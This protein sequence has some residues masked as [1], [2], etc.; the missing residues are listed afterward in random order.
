MSQSVV[1]H[2]FPLRSFPWQPIDEASLPFSSTWRFEIVRLLK[3]SGATYVPSERNLLLIVLFFTCCL[4]RP[5]TVWASSGCV[6]GSGTCSD[7]FAGAAGTTLSAYSASW[8]KLAGSADLYTMGDGSASINGQN[9]AVY[10]FALS[11]S[12]TSQITVNPSTT[13]SAYARDACVR[14][15]NKGNYCVG[16]GGVS[17]GFYNNCYVVKSGEYIGS[18]SCVSLQA[19]TNHTLALQASG[20][21]SVTLTIYVDGSS[22]GSVKD[23]ANALTSG[24]PGFMIIGDGT[25]SDTE[26][27]AWQDYIGTANTASAPAAAGLGIPTTLAFGCPSGSGSCYDTFTGTKNLP[28]TTYNPVWLQVN[29][30]AAAFLTGN[31]SVEIP[32]TSYAYYAYTASS[33]DTAQVTVNPSLARNAYAREACVR[34]THNVGGYCVGFGQAVSGSYSGCFVEMGGQYLGNGNCGLPSAALSH[35]LAI[36]AV[37]SSPTKLNIY[38]DG[39]L[40][41]TVNDTS[42]MLTT[43]HPGFALSGDGTPTDSD[44]GMWRDSYVA[45]VS[46]V[47]PKA[48]APVF[49]P[50][51]GTYAG[52]QVISITSATSGTTVYYTTD[53]STPTANSRAY[54]APITVSASGTLQA[55][56]ISNAYSPS[57]VASAAYVITAP[58]VASP[59]FSLATN[60][61]GSVTAVQI[62]DS[63]NGAAILYCQDTTNTC[64]PNLSYNAGVY[65]SST[66]YI[67]AMAT[68]N[69]FTPSAVASWYGVLAAAH[70]VTTSCPQGTQYQ[71]YAGCTIVASGGVP[72]YTFGVSSNGLDGVGMV[73]GL[74]LNASTGVI[75]G[76]VYGQGIY[77]VAITVTDAA[78]TTVKQ[79]VSMPMRGEN[80]LSG[81]SL[82]PADSIWHLNVAN[83]PVDTAMFAPIAPVYAP[84][85]LH[86]VFGAAVADGGIPFT[87]VP[88]DQA[89]V[90]VNTTM[91]QSYF[92]SAP[93]PSTA[94]VEGT[95]NAASYNGDRHTL[96]LQTAGG[97]NG[98]KLWEM[99]QGVPNPDGSWTDSSNASW[100]LT[101]YDMLPQDNGST[102]AAGLPVLPLL[103]NYDEVAGGCAQ[104]QECGVVTHPGRLT[105]NHTLNYHV[106]PAT[107]QAG[108][109]YCTGGYEDYNRLLSQSNPPTYCSGNSPMGEIYRL[110]SS[111]VTPAACVGHPQAQVLITAMRN[112]GLIVADNG[113]TGG[114]VA[115]A[116]SRW[117]DNDLAC[118]T[119]LQ[120]NDFE[121]VNVSGAMVDLNSSR[122]YTQQ[123]VAPIIRPAQ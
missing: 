22:V 121:P 26:A 117:N 32:G 100:D 27:S 91:Y 101:S 116:D 58:A 10:G 77:N 31:E 35:T 107:A 69:G 41:G 72:P 71:T 2:L 109:G 59:T 65:F 81:C 68:L 83:L 70:I 64:T 8:V 122:V 103:W 112:Y 96:V 54:T 56:A 30:T 110:K 67:R 86:M 12:D 74:T 82:F 23:S 3:R 63:A 73:E 39:V 15:S 97:G 40:T 17:N 75:S 105:L 13:Q 98:C 9:Y 76:K 115:T 16:F 80:T 119:A 19:S 79:Q 104:G 52:T 55:V 99:W 28:L 88:Y 87:K 18:A 46:P 4:F 5:Q 108:L 94:A 120:L 89:M 6:S 38:L 43:S 114:I 36:A 48:V 123:S 33:A 34:L 37:G 21:S 84:V 50:P 78:N 102:D 61:S 118:L 24:E 29:G 49:T 113:I 85:S 51:A 90:P 45:A 106:W 42:N 57:P 93:Y 25:P 20:T 7:S 62:S 53:G 14:M 111:T 60:Y 1:Q 92:T 44:A 66:G 47:L 11:T 95:Q